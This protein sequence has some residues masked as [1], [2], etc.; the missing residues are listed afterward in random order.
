MTYK[1]FENKLTVMRR[2]SQD[3]YL[4]CLDT[5]AQFNGKK[6]LTDYEKE[7]KLCYDRKLQQ[8]YSRCTTI[9]DV[10]I[11]YNQILESKDIL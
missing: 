9:L 2:Q 8:A 1:D 6:E 3:D 4:K 7:Q 5:L 11:E 10:L